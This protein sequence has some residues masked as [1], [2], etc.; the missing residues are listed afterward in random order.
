MSWYASTTFWTAAAAVFTAVM[1]GFTGWSIVASQRQQ[2]R[3]LQQSDQH[4][5][6]GFR[7]VLVLSTFDGI[8]P[9]DRSALLCLNPPR[10][11]D[12]TRLYLI[13]CLLR[14]VGVGPALKVHLSLRFMGIEGYGISRELAPMQAGERRGDADHPVAVQFRPRGSFNDTDVLLSVGTSWELLLEYEDVFGNRFHTIHSKI[15]LQPWTVCGKGPAPPGVDPAVVNAN[16][17]AM[18]AFAAGRDNGPVGPG[19]DL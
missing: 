7:P 4:H 1:A 18:S 8:D 13:P 14:N 2:R 10:P 19:F 17:A 12:A 9:L 11:G 16:L 6:D 15:P 5:Q 3:A